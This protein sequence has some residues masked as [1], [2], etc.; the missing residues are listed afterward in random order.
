[1]TALPVPRV[2]VRGGG[3]LATGVA[4]RL[5]R[6]GF[7]V[8]VLE[9]AQ[10][11]FIRR[12]VAFARAVLDGT[13]TVEGVAARRVEEAVLASLPY[14]PVHIDAEGACLAHLRPEVVVDARMTKTANDTRIDHAPLVVGLGPGFEVGRNCH[15]V[16][17]TER[18]HFL[19]RVLE[20]GCARPDSGRPGRLGGHDVARVL[21]APC[22]GRFET[23]TE[24]G[25]QVAAGDIVGTV[26][27]V[28][29]VSA[30]A[31]TVRG[32]LHG[33]TR[34]PR[35]LKVGDVDP[36]DPA[37][38]SLDVISEKSRAIGGGVLEAILSW[39]HRACSRP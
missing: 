38:F 1:M 24:L 2:V 22:E 39:R 32:L 7:P 16:V 12:T 9:L 36:R 34:V 3:D 28:P 31:G 20:S 21:R 26:D 5:H 4:W 14:V 15:C 13:C 8:L 11:L 23:H 30:I 18:G 33:G 27:G 10:P 37:A 6:C 25:A 17:E 29:V 35:G 19:G